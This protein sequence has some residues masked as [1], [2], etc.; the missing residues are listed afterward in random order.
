MPL[1]PP[2]ST[3]GIPPPSAS[4]DSLI[5]SDTI[6][7]AVKD[8]FINRTAIASETYPAIFGAMLQFTDGTPVIVEYYKKRS[9]FID[10]QTTDTSF[11][12]ERNPILESYDLIHN[13][14]L[15]IKDQL[16][17]EID[18][19]TT[20]TTVQGTA[21]VY[22]G[23]NPNVG[24]IFLLNLPDS[25]VGVFVVNLTEPLSIYRGSHYQISFHLKA[26]VT[27]EL[28]NHLSAG[29]VD[30]LWFDKQAYFTDEAALLTDTSYN[31]LVALTRVRKAIISRLM[32]KFYD[33]NEKTII[34]PDNAYDHYVVNY[35]MQKIS[36]NDSRKDLTQIPNPYGYQFEH[37]IWS[38]LL[39]Q[40]MSNLMLVGYTMMRYQQYLSDTNTSNIDV[41]SLV[42][43]IDPDLPVD[44][45]RL[46]Q[47]LFNSTDANK[48]QVNYVF[49]SRLYYALLHSF[50]NAEV[51]TDVTPHLSDIAADTRILD[52]LYPTFYS[53][54]DNAYHEPAFFDTHS[55]ATGSNNDM[56]LPEI[57]F[58]VLDFILN[59]NVDTNYL[60]N[61]VLA[62]FP[63]STM[64]DMDQLYALS[65]LLHLT[66][67]ALGRLR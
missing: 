21:V 25:N 26:N 64:T 28:F 1:V 67:V 18:Q 5:T 23:I 22:P 32:N 3:G 55:K 48:K 27:A 17:I 30:E 60:T 38:A 36:V 43:L 61:T 15:R 6:A 49:S 39:K 7:T 19:E 37:T 58:M 29:V 56:H 9:P 24:D 35:L 11:S 54:A 66:D 53:V 46:T 31:N 20:E 44:G 2:L 16:N 57:E 34:R 42:Y 10:R 47:V 4:G 13:F 50:E 40:D 8:T 65:I 12:N 59:N 14:E 63:F 51:I 45:D 41:R 33:V 62:K 52:D